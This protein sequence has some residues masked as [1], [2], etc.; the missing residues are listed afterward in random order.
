M[1]SSIFTYLF[2]GAVGALI[3]WL[4]YTLRLGS[5]R[6]HALLI[7]H[8]AEHE[9]EQKKAGL[10]LELQKIRNAHEAQIQ[11]DRFR[12]ETQEKELKSLLQQLAKDTALLKKEQTRL[13]SWE[14]EIESQEQ[15]IKTKEQAATATLEQI[16]HLSF[17]EARTLVLQKAHEACQAEIEQKKINWQRCF[18]SECRFRATNLL[19]SAIER[20]TQGLTKDTFLTE[21]LLKDRS[22]IPRC[23]GK[24]GRNIQSLEEQLHVSILIEEQIPRLLISAHDAKSRFIAKNTIERLIEAEKVTPVTIRTAHEAALASFSMDIE[25][26]G[27]KALKTCGYMKSVPQDVAST[28][29]E[30]FFRSS[31]GQNVLKHSLE[32]A[33]MMGILAKELGLKS[34]KAKAMGLF[35]DIGKALSAEWGHSHALAGKAFLE[36]RGIDT[37]IA[38]AVASHHGEEPPLTEEARLVPVCDRLSAQLPGIRNSQEPAFLSMVHLCEEQTKNL[39]NVLSTWAHYAGN[40]I[41][42]VVRHTPTDQTESILQSIHEALH[43]TNLPIPVNITLLNKRS[44]LSLT[45]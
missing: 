33:E 30:L 39:P 45:P 26:Q 18:E 22:F 25:E 21:I 15:Q 31:S 29:G 5:F 19:F 44:A 17:E 32:V 41:E 4:M 10:T 16:S 13:S 36:K 1:E 43:S 20:K 34:E 23:I 42:L 8:Q 6:Q 27:K 2:S 35:H 40:H 11:Q 38:N 37:E 3:F 24:D 14:K 12:L 7:I 28:L 9:A